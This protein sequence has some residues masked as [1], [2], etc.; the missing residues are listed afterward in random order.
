MN[1]IKL[2]PSDAEAKPWQHGYNL[3]ELKA[4]AALFK[5]HDQGLILGAFTAAK[6]LA[7]ANWL[8]EGSLRIFAGDSGQPLC[9]IVARKTSSKSAVNDFTG[10]A[11]CTIPRGDFVIKRWAVGPADDRGACLQE[12][13]QI[14]LDGRQAFWTDSWA[15]NEL[16]AEIVQKFGGKLEA[17]KIAA[18]SEIRHINQHGGLAAPADYSDAERAHL[19]RVPI[20]VDAEQF[21]AAVK[22]VENLPQIWQQHYSGYNKV[23]SWTAAALRGYGG[24]ADFIQKPHEM[25]KKWKEENADKMDWQPADTELRSLLPSLEPLIAKIPAQEFQRIRLMKITSGGGELTRH[26]DITDKEAGVRVGAVIRLHLPIITN[27][28][29]VFEGW[30]I[31]GK[32]T[33]A[34]MPAGEWWYLDQ[35]KPH[36]A[37]NGGSTDRIHLVCDVVATQALHDLLSS[38][39]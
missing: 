21:A 32:R 35:R 37:R 5:H 29:V 24:K 23:H 39:S 17:V 16:D 19:I 3:A 4:V 1:E 13:L 30:D 34:R 25:S 33:S 12:A 20:A 9:A 28:D 10:S 15:E 18:S 7:V 14:V 22:E 38:A 31:Y 8:H 36:T 26:A 6:E 2:Q 27:P 11:R